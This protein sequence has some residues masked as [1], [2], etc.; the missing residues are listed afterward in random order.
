MQKL[1]N[2]KDLR[3]NKACL[4]KI[5]KFPTAQKYLKGNVLADEVF[6][7]GGCANVMTAVGLVKFGRNVVSHGPIGVECDFSIWR[8]WIDSRSCYLFRA[9]SQQET[10]RN[11]LT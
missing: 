3:S 1:W 6:G 2:R 9:I 4:L 7:E 11:A 5:E 10:H 8:L